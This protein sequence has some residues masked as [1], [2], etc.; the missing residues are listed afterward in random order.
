MGGLP[1]AKVII[2]QRNALVQTMDCMIATVYLHRD[3]PP[4]VEQMNAFVDTANQLATLAWKIE[5]YVREG[6][7]EY[8]EKDAAG[9][10]SPG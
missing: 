8:E 2:D 6:G 5:F 4:T 7:D 9:D 3:T 10:G 1:C